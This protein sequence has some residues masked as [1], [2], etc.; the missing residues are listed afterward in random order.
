VRIFG[1]LYT[2]GNS[3]PQSGVTTAVKC[4]QWEHG[5]PTRDQWG[6]TA[7]ETTNNRLT[8]NHS[9]RYR[10]EVAGE[11]SASA[12]SDPVSV[13]VYKNGA[14][15]TRATAKVTV[16]ANG[17]YFTFAIL[18]F[19]ECVH[20]DYFEVYIASQASSNLLLENGTFSV[21]CVGPRED[22]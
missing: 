19:D 8:I 5:Y 20:G 4:T 18:A 14:A 12:L 13:I 6:V 22:R 11:M 16:T 7:D 1:Q 17:D 15:L 21:T 3:T 9:G 10:I 2:D